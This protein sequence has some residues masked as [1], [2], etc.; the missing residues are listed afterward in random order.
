MSSNDDRDPTLSKA[1]RAHSREA[2]PAPLDEKILAAAHRAVASGPRKPGAQATRPQ[3]WW[4][5]LAAAAAIGAVAI[6]VVQLMP[7]EQAIDTTSVGTPAAPA[8]PAAPPPAAAPDRGA[9]LA[10]K[11]REAEPAAPPAS[12]PKAKLAEPP[13][14]LPAPPRE[15]VRAPEP[16]PAAPMQQ[17]TESA[18][19]KLARSEMKR[20]VPAA[21]APA[22]PAAAPPPPPAA[23][24]QPSDALADTR[25]DVSADRQIAASAP[26]QAPIVAAAPA[27]ATRMREE[28]RAQMQA[29][30]A[31]AGAVAPM[32]KNMASLDDEA[33]AR[34]RDPD[35]WIVRIRKLRD[36]GRTA[37][38]LKELKEFRELVPDAEKRL[39]PDLRELK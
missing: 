4:M 8:A 36:A 10:K 35:A 25:K 27:P 20:D 15:G 21:E 24:A 17:K 38:A 12:A 31:A 13:K 33:R 23:P 30:A 28:A 16:F 1:W 34:A 29:P 22:K 18:G 6:G 14:G 19:G 11:Q 37:D 39:P 26:A 32:P 3:R 5:P 2:P 7:Q 9:M